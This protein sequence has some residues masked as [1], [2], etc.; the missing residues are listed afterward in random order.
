MTVARLRTKGAYVA[1]AALAALLAAIGCEV[2]VPSDVSTPTCTMTPYSDPGN[3]TCPAGMFCEGAGCK[4]CEPKDVC[5]GFDNDCD[6]IIDDGPASDADSDGYT[7][8]GK[9]NETTGAITDVDCNDHDPKIYPGAQEVCNGKDD[10]CDGIIDNPNLVCPPDETCVPQTGRCISNASACVSCAVSNT[11]G[12]CQSPNVCDP[13]TQACVTPGAKDA[14]TS[15]TGDLA[16]ATGICSDSAELGTG[17]PA[18]AIAECTQPCCTSAD[19]DPASICW[20]AGTG[21]N[22]CVSAAAASRSAIGTGLPGASCSGA[23]DCR[24][25]VCSANRC[26][27]TC[28][29]NASCTGGTSCTVTT[30]AGNTTLACAVAGK[31]QANQTCNT[32]SDC[33]SGYCQS[34]CGDTSCLEV[35]SVCA[36]PCCSSTQCGTFTQDGYDQQFVCIDDY[37]PPLTMVGTPPAGT[38]VV[39]VC[40]FPQVS[41]T[42]ANGNPGPPPTGQ[43]GATCTAIT[44][45]FSNQCTGSA[46]K[47]GYC[48]DVCCVDSDCKTSGYVCRPQPTGTGTNLRCVPVSSAE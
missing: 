8:C 37:Y 42:L 20:G 40:D 25:G 27:D 3:G 46:S 15:C 19:C 36:S 4:A 22:Y 28:C 31:T 26:E 14:G 12:C 39:P 13:G 45:C 48:T 43:V 5:D 41:A 10:N 47:P 38:P 7:Y 33:A 23:G 11:A 30:L 35:I 32:G 1:L 16:C 2:I 24:S 34:Y 9:E 18:G 44:D 29:T 21:G 17:A 6:G